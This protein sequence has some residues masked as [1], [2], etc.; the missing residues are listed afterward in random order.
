MLQMFFKLLLLCYIYLGYLSCYLLKGGDSASKCP[1][2][3]PEQAF[4]F[5]KF[6]ALSH[7]GCKNSWNS[8]PTTFKARY[9]RDLSSLC[10]LPS[11]I[12]CFFPSLCHWLLTDHSWPWSRYMLS[13]RN[14]L[15]KLLYKVNG[16][17]NIY[18]ANSKQNKV[19]IAILF[20]DKANSKE[21]CQ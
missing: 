9:Y 14:L 13:T 20:S 16:W 18:H 8:A 12:V 4:W 17:K 6:Q 19:G 5:L 7:V 10:G 2:D 3:F 11:V 1:P 15:S 21:S